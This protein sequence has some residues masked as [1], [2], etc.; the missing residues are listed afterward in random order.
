MGA[1]LEDAVHIV[2]IDDV[3]LTFTDP[4][5]ARAD[6][7]DRFFTSL[8]IP[9]GVDE[10]P[11]DLHVNVLRLRALNVEHLCTVIEVELEGEI[12]RE[13]EWVARQTGKRLWEALDSI[14][15]LP[16]DLLSVVFRHSDVLL[17]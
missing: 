9:L 1:H 11:R 5:E 15:D 13:N 12:G 3:E 2:F 10:I 7:L 17:L 4:L 6:H 16:F 8:T 14:L